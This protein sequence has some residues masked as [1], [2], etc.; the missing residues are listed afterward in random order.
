MRFCLPR[1][2]LAVIGCLIMGCGAPDEQWAKFAQQ[3]AQEQAAQNKRVAEAS[4]LVAQSQERLIE[5]D[6]Q[7]RA[8]L[9]AL[10]QDLRGDQVE[11]GRLRDNLE[12][13]RRQ[14]A[15]QRRL[16]S[17]T[18]AGLVTL[19]LLLVCLAPLLLAAAS[20]LGLFAEPKAAEIGV[21]LADELSRV[22]TTPTTTTALS[23]PDHVSAG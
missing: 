5:A 13:E 3:A 19:G 16:D 12:V 8:E 18:G 22:A 15:Q 20:L 6:A 7:S 4:R 23:T 9:I 17:A 1:A 11:V 14:I 21:V 10:Q 2:L